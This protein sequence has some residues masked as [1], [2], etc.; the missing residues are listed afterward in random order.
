MMS[1]ASILRARLLQYARSSSPEVYVKQQILPY[2]VFS[3]R[4]SSPRIGV[5]LEP[6]LILDCHELANASILP[7]CMAARSLDE[8]LTAGRPVWTDVRQKIREFLGTILQEDDSNPNRTCLIHQNDVDTHLPCRVGDFTDFFTCAQHACRGNWDRLRPNWSSLPVAYHGRASSVVA[9]GRWSSSSSSSTGAAEI[10]RPNGQFPLEDENG[11]YYLS[12]GPSRKLDYE[13]E[14]GCIIGGPENPLGTPIT[15]FEEAENRIFGF[16]LLNDLSARDIQYWE[17]APLGPFL[18]KS[19]GSVISPWIVPKDAMDEIYR[20]PRK[21][22]FEK[23]FPPS[24]SDFDESY[25]A[26]LRRNMFEA[27]GK[28]AS[29]SEPTIPKYLRITD[30]R[31]NYEYDVPID[32][33]VRLDAE[34]FPIA[35]TNLTAMHWNWE[36][37][38]IHH[39]CN[40]CNLRPGDLLGSGTLSLHD[41]DVSLGKDPRRYGCLQESTFEGRAALQL[42]GESK[43]KTIHRLYLEDGDECVIRSNNIFGECNVKIR[44]APNRFLI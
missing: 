18:G 29:S 4:S 3:S 25:P 8:F 15:S 20:R 13:V 2:G 16:A 17:M 11:S 32:V 22:Q 26:R 43:S 34:F 33:G 21:P 28:D 38:I 9:G 41:E 27:D 10:R 39:T 7:S 19:L 31:Y 42:E 37:M 1:S 14:V 5:A 30:A 35:R 24:E 6:D 12:F 23:G 36:Q 44:E 40:G